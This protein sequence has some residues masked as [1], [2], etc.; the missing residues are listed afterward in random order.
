MVVGSVGA[1]EVWINA[2]A[3]IADGT[4]VTWSQLETLD[5]NTGTWSAPGE[6]VLQSGGTVLG[7]IQ[8]LSIMA[9]DDPGASVTFG[10]LAGSVP[11]NFTI[12]STLVSFAALT[13]PIGTAAA[14]VT[15]SD[16][17]GSGAASLTGLF[18]GPFSFQAQYNSG[19]GVFASLDSP[20]STSFV[21]GSNTQTDNSGPTVIAGSV[22]NI[23]AVFSFT[24]SANDLGSGS[25]NFS[26]ASQPVPEP[27]TLGLFALG[28]MALAGLYRRRNLRKN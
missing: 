14:S 18:P 26:I 15:V 6:I 8:N 19:A 10:V 16:Q 11:T 5:P 4:D 21:H 22:S 17:N 25:G 20:A 1:T 27:G 24:L 23:Q 2:T 13:N 7:T 9:D 28:S 3:S 12:S